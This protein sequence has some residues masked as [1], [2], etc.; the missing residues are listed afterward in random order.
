MKIC[1]KIIFIIILISIFLCSCFLIDGY[2][3][4]K[5]A[6]NEMSIEKLVEKVE[7]KTNYSSIEDIP[8]M[9]I[10]AVIAVEDH[11]F[12]K[13]H[14]IDLIAI[15]RAIKH[16]IE[17]R[18]FVEGGS[19]ITQQV[20]KNNYFTQDKT[21][22]RKIAEMFMAFKLENTLN[23]N[24]ILELYLNTSYFG[25]GYYTIKD[26]SIGYFRKE[27]KYLTN[28]ECIMLAGVLNAPSAYNPN[29]NLHLAKQREKQVLKKLVK[30]NY[31][32]KSEANKIF[33]EVNKS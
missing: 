23:K 30:Y 13:H 6:I 16:D 18:D 25:S 22:K 5:K 1:L 15:L 11:R 8:K 12:Y 24:E 10:D 3:F 9:H 28:G 17:A 4:Y 20:A 19:T 29:E 33:E 27:P 14:G 2:I 7:Q 21:I 26:A 32:T 31:L